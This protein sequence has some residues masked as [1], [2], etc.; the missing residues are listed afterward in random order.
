MNLVANSVLKLLLKYS[1]ENC[2]VELSR[3]L[4]AVCFPVVKFPIC[5]QLL[6]EK[7]SNVSKS[8]CNIA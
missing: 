2:W 8:K 3:M 7:Y 1:T 5:I 6:S 4:F